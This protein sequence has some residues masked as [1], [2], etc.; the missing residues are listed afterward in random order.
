[1]I[2]TLFEMQASNLIQEAESTF[3]NNRY[4]PRASIN[5]YILLLILLW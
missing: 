1:M 3:Y 4:T 2:L 5:L